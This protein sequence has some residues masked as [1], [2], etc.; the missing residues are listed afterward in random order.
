MG[1]NN[2][3]L[4]SS[5]APIMSLGFALFPKGGPS[6]A[7]NRPGLE[8]REVGGTDHWRTNGRGGGGALSRFRS[9]RA[10]STVATSGGGVNKA[11]APG[12]GAGCE[13]QPRRPLSRS[14]PGSG[15]PAVPASPAAAAAAP[16]RLSARPGGGG[17]ARERRVAGAG[18]APLSTAPLSFVCRLR[19]RSC[20]GAQPCSLKMADGNEDARADDLPGPAFEGYE[21]MELACPAE[22]SG[23]VAVSDGRHMFVWGGYKVSGGGAG[24]VGGGRPPWLLSCRRASCF[25]AS[26]DSRLLGCCHRSL[27]L[28][29]HPAPPPLP[30]RCCLWSDRQALL[31][32]LSSG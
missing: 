1:L 24:S 23:H 32:G 13:C 30:T 29:S 4:V 18:R 3:H 12:G 22:R 26:V 15:G 14:E 7:R 21:A 6:V 8:R 2:F 17:A 16:A 25:P 19:G 11:L 28:M 9:A 10:G 20:P 27:G 31:C 5:E